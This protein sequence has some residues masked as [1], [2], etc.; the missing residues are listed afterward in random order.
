LSKRETEQG[1]VR[2]VVQC[3]YKMFPTWNKSTDCPMCYP[4]S[5]GWC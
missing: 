5:N 4:L 3:G 1:G 2:G